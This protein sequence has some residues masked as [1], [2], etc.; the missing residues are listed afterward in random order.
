MT[1]QEF[2]DA[3]QGK[4]WK[5]RASGPDYYDCYGLII[6]Y[7][8]LVHSIKLPTVKG[9]RSG[10]ASIVDGFFSQSKNGKWQK[11]EFKD[12]VVFMAFQGDVPAHC[13]VVIGDFVLHAIGSTETPGQVV[14]H[15]K[16]VIERN[17]GKV[18][19]WEFAG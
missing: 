11:T 1:P 15:R 3:T 10:K 17:Y 14:Y 13:G 16:R 7:F 2:I 18:E 19:Y 4:P 12:G 8:D 5:D 6:K 9:Y